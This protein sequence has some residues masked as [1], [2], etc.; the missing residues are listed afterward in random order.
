MHSRMTWKERKELRTADYWRRWG[1][2]QIPCTACSGSGH[3]DHD[4]APSCGSCDG[5]G[6][7]LGQ[8]RPRPAMGGA[9]AALHLAQ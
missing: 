3:Y 7:E 2:K 8:A 4:G 9:D 1:A 5:K 6:Y